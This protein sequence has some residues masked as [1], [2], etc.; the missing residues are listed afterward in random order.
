L[1]LKLPFVHIK[2]NKLFIYFKIKKY[3]HYLIIFFFDDLFNIIKNNIKN[4]YKIK[5]KNA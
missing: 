2:K 1:N 3:H 4:N 5:N